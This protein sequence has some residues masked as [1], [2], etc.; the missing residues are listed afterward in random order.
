MTT[1]L[2]ILFGISLIGLLV[3]PSLSTV[4]SDA[5]RRIM[6]ITALPAYAA[7]LVVLYLVSLGLDAYYKDGSSAALWD[8]ICDLPRGVVRAWR[9]EP[10][11]GALDE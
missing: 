1:L 6:M 2:C 8:E 7:T 4:K 9:G 10:M 3:F 11:G 5:L